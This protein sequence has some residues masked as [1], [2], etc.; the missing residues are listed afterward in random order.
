MKRSLIFNSV[1]LGLVL[2]VGATGCKHRPTTVT[3]LYDK[4]TGTI[5]DPPFT[6]NPLDNTGVGKTVP[7]ETPVVKTGTTTDNELPDGKLIEGMIPDAD[8]FKPNTAYFEYDRAVVR[9]TERSKI[10]GVAVY[11]KSNLDHKLMI[12]GHCDERGT[13]EYNRALGER[14]ALALREYLIKLGVSGERLYTRT[15]GEDRPAV[16]GHDEPAWSK[17]RRGEFIDLR[18]KP[19]AN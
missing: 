14:R 2:A 1:L 5:V 17:N 4:K 18:P 9:A 16:V 12:D 10:E 8:R 15:Y 6:P 13:E 3:S 11:M 7:T 19:A